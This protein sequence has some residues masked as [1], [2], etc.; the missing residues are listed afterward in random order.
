MDGF[1]SVRDL[2]LRR[3]GNKCS[4][5]LP[6]RPHSQLSAS[7]RLASSVN[8]QLYLR[9]RS[10]VTVSVYASSLGFLFYWGIFYSLLPISFRH[11]GKASDR[12]A[13]CM[14]VHSL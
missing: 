12:E 14:A 10:L 3:P 11:I 1:K 2:S 4:M 8:L 6:Q 5:L 13:C 7:L 9:L